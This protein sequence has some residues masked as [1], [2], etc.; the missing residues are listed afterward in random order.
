MI[1]KVFLYCLLIF[2]L[3]L[4]ILMFVENQKLAERLKI[5]TIKRMD[6]KFQ[7]NHPQDQKIIPKYPIIVQLCN[8]ID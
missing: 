2:S 1:W 5:E 6:E 4:N 7:R 3:T 8:R